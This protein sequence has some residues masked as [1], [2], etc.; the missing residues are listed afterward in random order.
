VEKEKE[1]TRFALI[2]KSVTPLLQIKKLK[3]NS[4]ICEVTPVF[5]DSIFFLILFN[6]T[7]LQFGGGGVQ[8]WWKLLSLR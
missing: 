4:S 3:K 7:S 8:F 1:S 2:K 6:F 5:A